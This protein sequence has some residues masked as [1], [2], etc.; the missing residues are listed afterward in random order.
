MIL[1]SISI[2]AQ[3]RF[4]EFVDG[5]VNNGCYEYNEGYV[6]MGLG[7][8]G[9]PMEHEFLYNDLDANGN[10]IDQLD[11]FVDSTI[12]TSSRASAFMVNFINETEQAIAGVVRIESTNQIKGALF[13]H[14]IETE[15]IELLRTYSQAEETYLHMLEKANDST[16]YV[17]GT[18]E[19][20]DDPILILYDMTLEGDIRCYETWACG[21]L[22]RTN[23]HQILPHST[24]DEIYI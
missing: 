18:I 20:N 17:A 24:G 19:N 5:W 13:R 23:P 8:L 9:V 14:N 11:F 3:D 1:C 2:T 21:N 7:S 16:L 15:E 12:S 10:L 22:C 6:F 4:F